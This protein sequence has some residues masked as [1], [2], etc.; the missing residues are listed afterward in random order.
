MRT[1][2]TIALFLISGY[3]CKGQ[4]LNLVPID[5][6]SFE[7][8]GDSLIDRSSALTDSTK[9]DPEAYKICPCMI[10]GKKGL[11]SYRSSS[12]F[13]KRNNCLFLYKADSEYFMRVGQVMNRKDASGRFIWKI[14]SN[15]IK[16]ELAEQYISKIKAEIDKARVP[17]F[18]EFV[19]VND[20][21]SHTFGDLE[22]SKYATTPV[23][24]WSDS[25]Q[26]LIRLS[27]KIIKKNR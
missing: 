24:Y 27:E 13:V 2:F 21:V 9:F 22:R 15:K 4:N 26:D 7:I 3:L 18:R 25:V 16:E 5:S 10:E 1:S 14:S 11:V 23:T 12:F 8:V 6:A 19:I 17:K 20:G